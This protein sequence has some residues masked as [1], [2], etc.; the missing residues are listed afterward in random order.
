MFQPFSRT[1]ADKRGFHHTA[2]AVCNSLPGHYLKLH[3]YQYLNIG[4]TLTFSIW[5]TTSDG[6][7]MTCAATASEVRNVRTIRPHGSTTYVDATYCYRRSRV[8]CRSVCRSLCRSVTVV[9]PAKTA[10]PIEM[11]FEL[12]TRVQWYFRELELE[13]EL[14]LKLLVH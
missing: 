12:R 7:Y 5:P 4:S 3:H 9:S 6:N 11:S 1:D 2:P 13:V 10:K 8:V 14:K